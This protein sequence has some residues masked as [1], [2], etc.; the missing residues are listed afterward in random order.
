MLSCSVFLDG[1]C[2]WLI[3]RKQS[4][5]THLCGLHKLGSL[6]QP[7]CNPLQASEESR[8]EPRPE[9]DVT[10]ISMKMRTPVQI[11]HCIT[12]YYIR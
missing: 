8:K 11:H 12:D 4:N 6:K 9:E 7:D 3:P 5:T 10:M 2:L 1:N